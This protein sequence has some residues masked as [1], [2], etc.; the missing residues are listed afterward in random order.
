MQLEDSVLIEVSKVQ[1]HKACFCLIHG[2]LIQKINIYKKKHM[3]IYNLICKCGTT[4]WNLG[5]EGKKKRV[6]EYQ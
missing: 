4:I 6:I 3:I 2:R 1:K 5:K